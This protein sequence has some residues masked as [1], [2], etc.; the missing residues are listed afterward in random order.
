MRRNQVFHEKERLQVVVQEMEAKNKHLG[1]L[2]DKNMFNRAE[3]Y[4]NN[5]IERLSRPRE[6][7]L[8]HDSASEVNT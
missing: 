1:Q 2:L 6:R 5:I 8:Y 4:K 3:Q 7:F